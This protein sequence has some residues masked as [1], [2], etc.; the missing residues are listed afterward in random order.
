MTPTA[1]QNA[2]LISLRRPAPDDLAAIA[3]IEQASFS[4]P[5]SVS[6]FASILR[7]GH[8]IF[9]VAVAGVSDAIVGYVV[10]LA[11]VDEAEI[12]NIAVDPSQRGKGLGGK[13]LDAALA[14]AET[15]G[16]TSIFLEVRVSN[17]A[18]RALYGSRA[19]AELSRRKNYY[20]SPVE[21]ALVLRRAAIG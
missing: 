19:F 11:V 14:E 16:A 5:W 6:E 1:E 17:A 2:S 7:L 18:A 15:R 8:T 13:L 4:D 21:D 20:R 3:A 9:L 12:L 10:A